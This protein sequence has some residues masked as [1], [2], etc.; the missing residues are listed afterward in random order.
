MAGI[1][2]A[3]VGVLTKHEGEF[4]IWLGQ[5]QEFRPLMTMGDASLC[6]ERENDILNFWPLC[7]LMLP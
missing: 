3:L 5:N 6:F 2:T 1:I 7:A 4:E